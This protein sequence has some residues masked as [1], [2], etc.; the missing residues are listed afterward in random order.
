MK[1]KSMWPVPKG[2]GHYGTELWKRVGKALVKSGSLDDLDR[3]T[4]E[5]LCRVYERMRTAD[6]LMS[7][8][9]LTVDGGRGVPKKHPA[10]SVWK[11][12]HDGYVRLLTH[13]GLSPMARGMRVEPKEAES[14][15]G[16]SRFF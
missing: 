16:K 6:D 5:T 2:L 12:S 11:T 15:D 10:F 9:G 14:K 13:F 7:T 8:E 1:I 4:F 3:E